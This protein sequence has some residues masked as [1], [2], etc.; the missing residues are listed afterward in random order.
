MRAHGCHSARVWP[1]ACGPPHAAGGRGGM[2][3]LR[4]RSPNR[5]LLLPACRIPCL[6]SVLH[7]R[8]RVPQSLANARCPIVCISLSRRPSAAP[9][10]LQEI[11]P[12][13]L[14]AV[15]QSSLQPSPRAG[16]P[17]SAGC[18]SPATRPVRALRRGAVACRLPTGLTSRWRGAGGLTPCWGRWKRPCDFP[19]LPRPRYVS[20]ADHGD[21][22]Y[23]GG[24][25]I[26]FPSLHAGFICVG[27]LDES[28]CTP[29][30][31]AACGGSPESY[32]PSVWLSLPHAMPA[33]HGAVRHDQSTPAP[34]G[35]AGTL[36]GVLS[37]GR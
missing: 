17:S 12:Q 30:P 9:T 29:R 31:S 19:I 28:R 27:T 23:R 16:S 8:T 2:T 1:C 36:C 14:K 21:G 24:V 26:A 3:I 4:Q 33:C 11:L 15:P 6:G 18:P 34:G 37:L 22:Q 5:A 32:E 10:V 13:A 35:K 20:R 7:A 25:H